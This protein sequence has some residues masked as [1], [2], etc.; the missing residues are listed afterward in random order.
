MDLQL[1][2]KK[3]NSPLKELIEQKK[4]FD[5]KFS[6]S[7]EVSC[8]IRPVNPQHLQMFFRCASSRGSITDELTD[9]S[10]IKKYVENILDKDE[11]TIYIIP[12]WEII[13]LFDGTHK[14]TWM[15]LEKFLAENSLEL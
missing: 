7:L 6:A 4:K 8:L 10:L 12:T 3:E 9:N 14:P 15:Q 5:E 2:G 11:L 13:H 1:L